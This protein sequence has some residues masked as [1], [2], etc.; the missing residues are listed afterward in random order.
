MSH[1]LVHMSLSQLEKYLREIPVIT[2]T[3]PEKR[4]VLLLGGS[5]G[6]YLRRQTS[7]VKILFLNLRMAIS[8]C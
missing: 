8:C 6:N 5:K 2:P 7:Q 4:T 1:Y 3:S